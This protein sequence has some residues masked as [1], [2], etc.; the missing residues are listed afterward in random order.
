MAIS[1]SD[2]ERMATSG[3]KQL[4]V[5]ANDNEWQQVIQR[6]TKNDSEWYNEWES[7][8]ANK[9]VWF[10]VLKLNKRHICFMR[11]FIQFFMQFITAIYSAV[12]I[13][14]RIIED[15]YFQYN[16]LCFYHAGISSCFSLLILLKSIR[17]CWNLL[18]NVKLIVKCKRLFE[19]IM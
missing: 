5:K 11:V 2:S 6:V 19:N 4:R 3:N 7:M 8:R 14:N 16:M 18:K 12:K 10:L 15:I 17:P 13:I 9:R 1:D